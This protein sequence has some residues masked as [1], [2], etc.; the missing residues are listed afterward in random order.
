VNSARQIIKNCF[1]PKRDTSHPV[2]GKIMAFD[3]K[4]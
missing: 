3:T 1:R 2:I 4:G